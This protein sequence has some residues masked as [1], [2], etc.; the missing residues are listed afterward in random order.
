MTL[1]IRLDRNWNS[2]QLAKGTPPPCVTGSA[3][4]PSTR[5]HNLARAW[6]SHAAAWTRDQSPTAA[7]SGWDA[8]TAN[9]WRAAMTRDSEEGGG[10]KAQWWNA[11]TA[12]QKQAVSQEILLWMTPSE[13][14]TALQTSVC[15]ELLSP[16]R[17]D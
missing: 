13:N 10:R 1:T 16:T 2:F 14:L 9:A 15:S 7:R 5:M 6:H 3:I 17:A 8:S 4:A 12:A 11:L